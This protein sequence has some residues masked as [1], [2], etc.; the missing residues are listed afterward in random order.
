MALEDAFEVPLLSNSSYDYSCDDMCDG[1]LDDDEELDDNSSFIRKLFLKCQTLLLKKKF[2]KQKFL[3]LS[4]NFE[5]LKI[6]FSNVKYSN[7]KLTLDLKTSIFLKDK[8][9]KIK[10]ENQMLSKQIFEL[11]NSI[12]KFHKGKETIDNL[13]NSQTFSS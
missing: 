7:E 13:L 9:D 1:E 5:D 6:E 8:F 3:K 2:Y 11:K 4:N 10:E 12:F